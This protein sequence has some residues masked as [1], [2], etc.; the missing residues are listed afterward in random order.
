MVSRAVGVV[1]LVDALAGF[2]GMLY[3]FSYLITG[4]ASGASM[5]SPYGPPF[6]KEGLVLF[7]FAILPHLFKL[8]IGFL[9]IYFSRAVSHWFTKGLAVNDYE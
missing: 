1:L 2:T 6:T 4:V 7:S 9:M 5:R 8:I 3:M